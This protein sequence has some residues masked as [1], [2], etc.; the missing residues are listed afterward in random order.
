[1][2]LRTW[3]Q[4]LHLTSGMGWVDDLLPDEKVNASRRAWEDPVGDTVVALM[5]VPD[6][7]RCN[8]L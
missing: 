2:A 6:H 5:M 4:E 7:L 1:M 3:S 8:G